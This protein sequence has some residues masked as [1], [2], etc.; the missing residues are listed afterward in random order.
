MKSNYK[1]I[2]KAKAIERKNEQKL[3]AV[4]PKLDNGSGIYFLT[5][6]DENSADYLSAL[7]AY[8]FRTVTIRLLKLRF[9]FFASS[10]N[11]SLRVLSIFTRT[12]VLSLETAIDKSS[13][14]R[15]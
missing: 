9:C 10:D 6:V 14:W 5:R 2:A 3:L 8:S 4:N 7:F 1:N 11:L 13:F 15:L 12:P